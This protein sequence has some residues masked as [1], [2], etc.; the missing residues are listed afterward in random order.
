LVDFFVDGYG[1]SSKYQGGAAATLT[2]MIEGLEEDQLT[3]P[4]QKRL[5][6]LFTTAFELSVP[7]AYLYLAR[8]IQ[9]PG[10][11]ELCD[12]IGVSE[13][14][15]TISAINDYIIGLMGRYQPED[16]DPRMDKKIQKELAPFYEAI[17]RKPSYPLSWGKLN[18]KGIYHGIITSPLAYATADAF[19]ANKNYLKG[20]NE[21][22]SKAEI[23]QLYLDFSLSSSEI[24]FKLRAFSDPSATYSFTPSNISVNNPG[25]GN[26]AFKMK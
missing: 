17:G 7:D 14:E 21:M 23:K 2:D 5:H 12:I 22:V 13:D 6:K 1:I 20:L 25:N 15:L 9:T 3:T 26:M 11:Q 24:K 16:N 19:N 8:H 4:A 10:L 18:V